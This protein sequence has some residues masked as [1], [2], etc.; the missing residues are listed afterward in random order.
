VFEP[1]N[2]EPP[3]C[4]QCGA[5]TQR[6]WM[7]KPPNTIPDSCDIVSRNGEKHPIRFRSRAD[8]RLWLKQKGYRVND[9]KSGHSST[10]GKKWLE[11]A[12]TLA[13]RNGAAA[14]TIR[15]DDLPPLNYHWTGGEL[16]PAQVAE[17][18]RKNG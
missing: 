17:Y 1:V 6:A 4:P 13:T 3:A 7:T 11:D 12:E 16:T 2:V 10:G 14:G 8:H 15:D 5:I 18:R 9:D